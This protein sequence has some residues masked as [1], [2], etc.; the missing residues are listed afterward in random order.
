MRIRKCQDLAKLEAYGFILDIDGEFYNYFT[1][2]SHTV[3]VEVQT[4]RVEVLKSRRDGTFTTRDGAL[5]ARLAE[6]GLL[7]ACP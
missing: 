3:S 7:E 5:L 1:G 6:A 2:H 4:R